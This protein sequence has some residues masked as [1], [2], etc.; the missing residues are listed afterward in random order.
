MSNEPAPNDKPETEQP[1][2]IYSETV[3]D[4]A[5]NPR[6]VGDDPYP[7]GYAIVTGPCGDTMGM[8]LRVKGD[9]IDRITFWTDGC[10]PSI[11]CGSVATEMTTGKR[12]AEALKITQDDIIHRLGGLPDESRHCA[13][14]AANTVKEA[15]RDY[16]SLKNEPWKKAYRGKK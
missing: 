16:I 14:L 1:R 3:I 5:Q 2:N 13:L 8:W 12:V 11:A 6:N 4:H 7:D 10:G 9:I 15:V